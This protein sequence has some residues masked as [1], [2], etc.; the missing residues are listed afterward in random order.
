MATK[1]SSEKRKDRGDEEYS[2]KTGLDWSERRDENERKEACDF[3]GPY[4]EKEKGQLT[5]APSQCLDREK[6]IC[7]VSQWGEPEACHIVPFAFSS[8]D[9]NMSA[10]NVLIEGACRLFGPETDSLTELICS[11]LDSSD[12]AWNMISLAPQVHSLWAREYFGFSARE[13]FLG[14]PQPPSLCRCDG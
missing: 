8:N 9:E 4:H 10:S 5:L 1:S 6:K 3:P 13:L 14:P 12:K 11:N 7:L 2:P